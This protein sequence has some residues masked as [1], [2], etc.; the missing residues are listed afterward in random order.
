MKK[1]KTIFRSYFWGKKYF[2]NDDTQNYLVLQ[3]IYKYFRK[4]VNTNKVVEW[5]SK[6]LSD[7]AIKIPPMSSNF[8]EPLL[9]YYG[10]KIRLKVSGN[11]LKEDKMKYTYGKIVNIY[12][13][14]DK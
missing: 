10:I 5:K 7:E 12:R 13:L 2:E 11:I 1:L 6:G 4:I 9:D 8:F 14:W 3:P